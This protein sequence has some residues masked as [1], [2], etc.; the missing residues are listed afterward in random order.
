MLDATRSRRS[1]VE[2]FPRQGAIDAECGT[3]TLRGSDDRQLNVLDDVARHEYAGD[4]ARFVLSALDTAVPGELAAEALREARLIARR[5]VEEERSARQRT[6][7]AEDDLPQ[8][9]AFTRQAFDTLFNEP[10]AVALQVLP[11][12]R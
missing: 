1:P 10:D 3:R 9:T 5:H 12:A 7:A 4:T 2:V 11:F 8:L 6:A